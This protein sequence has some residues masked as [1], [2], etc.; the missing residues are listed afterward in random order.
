MVEESLRW[1]NFDGFLRERNKN[2]EK[3]MRYNEL[4]LGEKYRGG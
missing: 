4:K 3:G 1:G 2:I